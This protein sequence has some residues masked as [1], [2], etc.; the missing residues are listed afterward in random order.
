MAKLPL[1]YPA[2]I[3]QRHTAAHT[4]PAIKLLRATHS[5]I[6]QLLTELK[7]YL[8][9]PK[10]DNLLVNKLKHN[11]RDNSQSAASLE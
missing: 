11:G 4:S 8:L 3:Q 6:N 1:K 2:L 10:I 5:E 7:T 9:I